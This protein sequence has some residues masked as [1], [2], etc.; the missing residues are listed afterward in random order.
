MCRFANNLALLFA[1]SL[2]EAN[3]D[4]INFH[5]IKNLQIDQILWTENEVGDSHTNENKNILTLEI[6][7]ELSDVR[8]YY[9]R[10]MR[11]HVY[12][13]NQVSQGGPRT[14]HEV[15][16]AQFWGHSGSVDR[17]RIAR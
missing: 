6:S 17:V 15:G 11:T 16:I 3:A 4:N 14:I 8:L 2:M 9:L 10:N 1:L 7:I 13:C 12:C 5:E